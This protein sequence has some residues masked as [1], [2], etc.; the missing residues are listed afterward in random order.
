[1]LCLLLIALISTALGKVVIRKPFPP[2][3]IHENEVQKYRLEEYF[4]GSSLSFQI[5]PDHESPH[6]YFNFTQT[7][8]SET[9]PVP[10]LHA[11]R[12]SDSPRG[13]MLFTIN[14]EFNM[15]GYT[16][17]NS[18]PSDPMVVCLRSL[19]WGVKLDLLYVTSFTVGT[20]REQIVCYVNGVMRWLGCPKCAEENFI[21]TFEWGAS[22]Q[23]ISASLAGS[24]T[25]ATLFF[26]QDMLVAYYKC[27][28]RNTCATN[29]KGKNA[30]Y[31]YLLKGERLDELAPYLV[32]RLDA[33]FFRKQN[34]K[35]SE[36]H[37]RPTGLVICDIENNAVY[38][39]GISKSNRIPVI[40]QDYTFMTRVDSMATKYVGKNAINYASSRIG[41][42]RD[43]EVYSF[44]NNHVYAIYYSHISPKYERS[45]E[46]YATIS[47]CSTNNFH[48]TAFANRNVGENYQV[49]VLSL[50]R[51]YVEL[52]SMP[53]PLIL[54]DCVAPKFDHV[55]MLYR[56]LYVVMEFKVPELV[57]DFTRERPSLTKPVHGVLNFTVFSDDDDEKVSIQNELVVYP[58]RDLKPTLRV[59]LDREYDVH[60]YKGAIR[61]MILSGIYGGIVGRLELTAGNSLA[62]QLQLDE[63]WQTFRR[64]GVSGE[65][66]PYWPI[67]RSAREGN[68]FFK[69]ISGRLY[70]FAFTQD[71]ILRKKELSVTCFTLGYSR[72]ELVPC[73][74]AAMEEDADAIRMAGPIQAGHTVV[75]SHGYYITFSMDVQ[76]EQSYF[77]LY[78]WSLARGLSKYAKYVTYAFFPG[79]QVVSMTLY[80]DG[81][82]RILLVYGNSNGT[83]FCSSF[84]VADSSGKFKVS[85]IARQILPFMRVVS[86]TSMRNV[87]IAIA[88]CQQQQGPGKRRTVVVAIPFLQEDAYPITVPV[89][90]TPVD[91]AVHSSGLIVFTEESRVFQF[92]V[93]LAGA[94]LIKEIPLPPDWVLFVRDG[95]PLYNKEGSNT[96]AR[97]YLAILLARYMTYPPQY[98]LYVVDLRATAHFS[99]MALVPLDFGTQEEP[100]VHGVYI[101]SILENAVV[102]I[103][104]DSYI[105]PVVVRG[106]QRLVVNAISAMPPFRNESF[107][108]FPEGHPE[109]NLTLR[110]TEA[111]TG[112]AP[113]GNDVKN[114]TIYAFVGNFSFPLS[115]FIKGYSLIHAV[116]NETPGC[117][118]GIRAR[119]EL[120]QEIKYGFASSSF[121]QYTGSHLFIA[122]SESNLYI[123]NCSFENPSEEVISPAAHVTGLVNSSSR[124]SFRVLQTDSG[125]TYIASANNILGKGKPYLC[126]FNDSFA[127]I[128]WTRVPTQGGL[129]V[130]SSEKANAF[131]W[132]YAASGTFYG[133]VVLPFGSYVLS[134]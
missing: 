87:S 126:V 88:L 111:P 30:I 58:L 17:A 101:R 116:K 12:L 48:F 74:K 84:E 78:Q 65:M 102:L 133:E 54:F 35:V 128:Y 99:P 40:S 59:K 26:H 72:G 96:E 109:L 4:Y 19:A 92:S 44:F 24:L 115:A 114:D 121:M 49:R 61:T 11:F 89:E 118:A 71:V 23:K 3:E 66:S 106:V 16:L 81:S 21:L 7:L 131:V 39:V 103:V 63:K 104:A 113:Y 76:S 107:S 32:A 51:N 45:G 68:L 8:C 33:E 94:W 14:E 2:I 119:F 112:L 53:S 5:P 132:I 100:E 82:R 83:A 90:G 37:S 125:E 69:F 22:P 64:F 122:D 57:V 13:N 85:F 80:D 124:R 62:S 52:L 50:L 105:K 1:M 117:S 77:T 9:F 108:I 29:S 38:L 91:F 31:V 70:A 123:M 36:V 43:T 73:A 95:L 98:R 60:N 10:I 67:V 34:I 130:L 46:D 75:T 25:N 110:Y 55:L 79:D 134:Y 56:E 15:T 93:S 41:Q 129:S 47:T 86:M 20:Y 42:R 127:P 97:A 28:D 120:V 27:I 18:C 6:V